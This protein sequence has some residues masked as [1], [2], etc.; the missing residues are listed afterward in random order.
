MRILPIS[1]DSVMVDRG[2][3]NEHDLVDHAR[4]AEEKAESHHWNLT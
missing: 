1:I 4:F 2:T 3:F